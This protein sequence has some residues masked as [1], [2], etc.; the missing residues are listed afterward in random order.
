MIFR[1]GKQRQSET[2]LVIKTLQESFGA[3]KEVKLFNFENEFI[4]K[5]Q[6]HNASAN[7]A[8]CKLMAFQNIPKYGLE[9]FAIICFVG[10]VSFFVYSVKDFNFIIPLLGIYAATAFRLLPSAN[11]IIMN[12][13]ALRYG[14]PVIKIIKSE[15]LT[16]KNQVYFKDQI[17]KKINLVH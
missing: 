15:L 13:N 14:L 4:H 5:F 1:W 10:F 2:G 7:R 6:N 11:R 8:E 16:A 3:I 9:Y 17:N 12:I